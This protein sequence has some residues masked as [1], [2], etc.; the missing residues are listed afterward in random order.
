MTQLVRW[1]RTRVLTWL[2]ADVFVETAWDIF[3]FVF[4]LSA[5]VPAFVSIPSAIIV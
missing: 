2:A 3:D 1:W 5:S 4:I